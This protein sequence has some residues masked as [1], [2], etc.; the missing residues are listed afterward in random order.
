M[1]HA[2]LNR[3]LRTYPKTRRIHLLAAGGVAH[4]DAPSFG[5]GSKK[6]RHRLALGCAKSFVR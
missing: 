4:L 6:A 3:L 1:W 2:G 5:I